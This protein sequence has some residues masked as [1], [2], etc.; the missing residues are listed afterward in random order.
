MAVPL[1]ADIAAFIDSPDVSIVLARIVSVR[2]TR[3]T[4]GGLV[5]GVGTITLQVTETLVVREQSFPETFTVPMRRFADSLVA[6]RNG[7]D[8]WNTI[9]LT[10]GQLALFATKPLPESSM[11]LAMA[12][13]RVESEQSPEV[14]AARLACA[15]QESREPKKDQRKMLL[16]ALSHKEH[17]LRST[18]ARLLLKQVRFDRGEAAQMFVQAMASPAV[19]PEVRVELALMIADLYAGVTPTD[20]T[21]QLIIK[22]L[23]N[24]FF[25]EQLPERRFSLA[26]HLRA[27]LYSERM[28]N[29]DGNRQARLILVRSVRTPSPHDFIARL[30]SLSRK[31]EPSEREL[32]QDLLDLWQRASAVKARPH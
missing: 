8:E 28:S 24:A 31:A 15:I 18:A 32:L 10:E 20:A 12:A 26:S 5:L 21:D 29:A 7:A 3:Q 6:G 25:V 14:S 4:E 30:T 1:S 23:A 22:T 17:I 16:D 11:R 2:M 27:C 9:D 13:R 19:E